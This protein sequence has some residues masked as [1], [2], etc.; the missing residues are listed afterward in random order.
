MGTA[1]AYKEAF[2]Y[3]SVT[4]P[5]APFILYTSYIAQV[6]LFAVIVH[7]FA[8]IIYFFAAFN[9]IISYTSW[10]YSFYKSLGDTPNSF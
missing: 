9:T 3:P 1:F 2:Y 5:E 8:A 4:L 7:H 6:Y 10:R